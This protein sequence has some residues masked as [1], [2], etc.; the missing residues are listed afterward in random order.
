MQLAKG[1]EISTLTRF[2]RLDILLPHDVTAPLLE[3]SEEA[4]GSVNLYLRNWGGGGERE[5]TN[6][7][8]HPACSCAKHMHAEG[9]GGV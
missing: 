4:G 5:K 2:D 7:F 6:K 3:R 9:F 8:A 1:F